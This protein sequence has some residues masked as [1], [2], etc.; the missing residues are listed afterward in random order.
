MGVVSTQTEVAP[1]PNRSDLDNEICHIVC[2]LNINKAYCGT[3]TETDQFCPNDPCHKECVVCL[4]LER[5]PGPCP[6]CGTNCGDL[7]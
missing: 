2:A 5:G 3:D 1:T 7:P 4:D 6:I